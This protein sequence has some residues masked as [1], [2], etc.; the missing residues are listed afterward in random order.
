MTEA[1]KTE[2]PERETAL[3]R[4][5]AQ[6]R[7]A[8]KGETTNIIE[9][10][11]LL[12]EIREHVKHGEWKSWLAENFDL[13][14]RSALNYIGAAEYVESKS[15]TVALFDFENLAPTVLYWLAQRCNYN[16][17][18]EAA[19]LAAT[20]EGRVDHSAAGAICE[21]LA[22]ADA[23]SAGESGEDSGADSVGSAEENAE[24]EAILDGPPPAVPPPAPSPPPIDFALKSFDE[25]ISTLK[26]LMTKLPTQFAGTS[27]SADDL[28]HRTFHPRCK[29]SAVMLDAAIHIERAELQQFLRWLRDIDEAVDF[30]DKNVEEETYLC[31]DRCKDIRKTLNKMRG[32]LQVML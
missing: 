6:L 12:I 24:I 20:C 16:E 4:L 18:E 32:L 31:L 15:A 9:I 17:Q 2:A 19:I 29:E 30:I 26:R 8:L 1:K 11:K 28:E 10:G 22:L 27:H 13:S 3:D 21:K 7:S 23:D 5:A 14:Y 25:A